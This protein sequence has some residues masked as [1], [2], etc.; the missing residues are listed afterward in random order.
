MMGSKLALGLL[1]ATRGV[2]EAVTPEERFNALTR[3]ADGDWGDVCADDKR[4]NDDAVRDGD[5]VMSS[6]RSAAGTKFWI[7]TEADRRSTT[8]LLPEEY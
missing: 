5:R 2:L 4:A 1:F 6:Y 8:V 7:V 3:H